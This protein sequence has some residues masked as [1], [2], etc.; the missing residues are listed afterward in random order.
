LPYLKNHCGAHEVNSEQDKTQVNQCIRAFVE[1]TVVHVRSS[2]S[3]GSATVKGAIQKSL[4]EE[5]GFIELNVN[6]LIRE[7][8]DRRTKLGNR[9]LTAYSTGQQFSPEMYVQ[10]LQPIIF[11]GVEGRD[12]FLLVSH[13]ETTE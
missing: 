4:V 1:P 11:S 2:G 9:L 3:D 13:P 12:K 10:L 5:H 8:S 6:D 7:E